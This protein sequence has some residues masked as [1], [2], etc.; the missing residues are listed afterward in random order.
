MG[1]LSAEP[2][3]Y[4]LETLV[5]QS[6]P[7]CNLDCSYCY[8]PQ[9]SSKERMSRDTLARTFE[10]VFES[11]YLFEELTILWHAGEPLVP[12][13]AY[14]EEAFALLRAMRPDGLKIRHHFQT[15]G[16]L[17]DK[18]WV[19]FFRSDDI[20]VGLSIDGPQHL[21]DRARKTRRGEGTFEQAMRGLRVLRDEDFPFHVIT[22]LSEQSLLDPRILFDF[23]VANGIEKI[24]FN[25]EEIEGHH[26]SS[27][28]EGEAMEARMRAFLREFQMLCENNT[29]RI[30][31]RE[32]AGALAGILS[33]DAVR[34]GNPL[35]EPLRMVS[36][37]VNGEIGT[38]SPELLG[39]GSERHGPFSF[40]NVRTHSFDDVLA[41]SRFQSVNAEIERGLRKCRDSCGYYEICLGGCPANKWFENGSFESTDTLFCKL[42][43]KAV[44][45][46]VLEQIENRLDIN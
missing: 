27:S 6:T 43:K 25:I 42:A 19:D 10:R 4:C 26:R 22:V 40:G 31:V 38:F 44:I 2:R 37:G 45:D 7:F 23:Y 17:L 8:L 3:N 34:Y 14:Y 5:L 36:I 1:A 13:I 46:V 20:R 41:D 11:P 35:A 15:N 39:Y 9:R 12:G 30:E 24:G 33:P 28:L 18:D 29:A 16:V 32:F 21:H